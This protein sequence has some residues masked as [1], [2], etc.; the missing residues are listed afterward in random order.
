M[1]AHSRLLPW[2]FR[3]SERIGPFFGHSCILFFRG[4]RDRLISL[5]MDFAARNRAG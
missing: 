4:L 2:H 3:L 1:L 5:C